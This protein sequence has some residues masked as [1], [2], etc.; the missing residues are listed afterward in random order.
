MK[1]QI[2]L[3]AAFF[4]CTATF[5]QKDELKAAEKAIKKGDYVTSAAEITK[6]EAYLR[7]R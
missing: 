6:A 4:I 7:C 5:A 3:L 2:L 1:N